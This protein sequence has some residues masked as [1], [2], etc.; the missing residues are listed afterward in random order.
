MHEFFMYLQTLM[1]RSTRAIIRSVQCYENLSIR[2]FDFKKMILKIC[3]T[4]SLVLLVSSGGLIF[5]GLVKGR[6]MF[7]LRELMMTL[8]HKYYV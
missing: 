5:E 1:H 8:T 7:R 2:E 3:C 6:P 4:V